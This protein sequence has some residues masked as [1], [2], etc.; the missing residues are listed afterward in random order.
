MALHSLFL[1]ES[2]GTSQ[3]PT[4]GTSTK[5][6]AAASLTHTSACTDAELYCGSGR[7]VPKFLGEAL[8][9]V[10]GDAVGWSCMLPEPG[11]QHRLACP[12]P[13]C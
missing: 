9:V 6:R 3:L 13:I 7:S 10:G 2:P 12:L 8:S 1:Q 4:A 5:T 11:A